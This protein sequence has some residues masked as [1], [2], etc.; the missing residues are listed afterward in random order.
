MRF[1]TLGVQAELKRDGWSYL[2]QQFSAK[3][4]SRAEKEV[5]ERE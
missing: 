3:R 4:L 2:A 5:M 1:R